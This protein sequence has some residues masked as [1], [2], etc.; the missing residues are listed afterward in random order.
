MDEV[1]VYSELSIFLNSAGIREISKPQT[2]IVSQGVKG[3]ELRARV[4]LMFEIF[5]ECNKP[6]K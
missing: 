1:Y 5:K 4:L 6:T 2:L 3:R